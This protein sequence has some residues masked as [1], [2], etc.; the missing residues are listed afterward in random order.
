MIKQEKLP[1]PLEL[2]RDALK[3]QNLYPDHPLSKTDEERGFYEI[4]LPQILKDQ[5]EYLIKFVTPKLFWLDRIVFNKIAWFAKKKW[6]SRLF[7]MWFWRRLEF[8][9]FEG[10]QEPFM[11]FES[12]RIYWKTYI[13]DLPLYGGHVN[14]YKYMVK[15]RVEDLDVKDG[16]YV[17]KDRNKPVN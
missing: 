10:I 15:D 6:R 12:V 9:P 7:L 8:I 11:T 17:P 2:L 1:G 14:H 5:C 16:R 3:A 4:K 13:I